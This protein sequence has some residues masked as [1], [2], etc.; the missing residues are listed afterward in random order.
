MDGTPLVSVI[1][2]FLN[3]EEFIQEAIDSVFAQT[4]DN[5]ELLLVDDG[6]TDTST[7]IAV[8]WVTQHPGRVRYLEHGGHR[9][10]GAGASRN[11]G[12]RNARGK[13]VAFLDADDVWLPHKLEQQ[14]AILEALPAVAMVYGPGL[15]WYSWTGTPEDTGRDYIQEL[16]LQPNT[17]LQPPKLLS[18]FLRN[19]DY[20]PSSMAI[21]ARRD[22]LERVGGSEESFLSIYDDQV[23][24]AKLILE[25]PVFV[26][27]ECWYKY[28]QHA[29]QRCSVT[30]STGQQRPAR[31]AFLNWLCEYLSKQGVKDAEVWAILHKE[32]R[33]YRYPI[34]HRLLGSAQRL[35]RKAQ[36]ML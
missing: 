7:D 5:W 9:N 16:G 26:S 24:F 1:I 13:Y 8:Y 6:S 2:P 27:G 12:S 35:V 17:L 36:T 32:L 11:L 20:V 25:A 23:V 14:I 4:Y 30:V 34:L 19:E 3:T 22:A 18:L 29:G 33:P 10:R 31:L 15:W 28:R 21:L